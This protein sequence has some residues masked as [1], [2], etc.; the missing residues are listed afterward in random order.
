MG[1]LISEREGRYALAHFEVRP[2]PLMGRL[3]GARGENGISKKGA[4]DEGIYLALLNRHAHG[5]HNRM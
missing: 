4:A 3:G 2:V 5:A 1:E